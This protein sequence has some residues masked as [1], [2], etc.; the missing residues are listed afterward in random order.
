VRFLYFLVFA[1]MATAATT[2]T[3]ADLGKRWQGTWIVRGADYPGSVQ[4]WDVKGD[5]VVVYDPV[6]HRKEQQ[7]FKLESPCRLVRT[8]A[9]GGADAISTTNTFAFGLD[10]LHVAPAQSPG[11]LRQGPNVTACIGEHVYTYDVRSHRCQRWNA[12]MTGAPTQAEECAVDPTGFVLRKLGGP[13]DIHLDSSGEGLLSQGLAAQV[14]ERA[15]SF[16]AAMHRADT[17]A[18][19]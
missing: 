3:V 8:Q 16:T 15:A 18:V 12:T 13:G 2:A 19:P 14:A 1:P 11:G 4:A 9:A 17:L 7:H 6:T 10:G 5:S